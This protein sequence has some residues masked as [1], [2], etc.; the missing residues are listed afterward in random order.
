MKKGISFLL[1]LVSLVFILSA[2]S[3]APE[4]SDEPTEPPTDSAA[5]SEEK[6]EE[7]LKSI[8]EDYPKCQ[9]ID[10][11]LGSDE[12]EPIDFVT[13]VWEDETNS[14]SALLIANSLGVGKVAFGD[15]RILYR[16]E[17][18]LRLDKNVIY[19]SFDFIL[20]E[21]SDGSTT[22]EIHDYELA[23]TEEEN[24]DGVKGTV[25]TVVKDTTRQIGESKSE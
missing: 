11:V 13:A 23:V 16:P 15:K 25:Y 5:L 19:V 24:D 22:Y 6:T 12:N 7:Y 20:D 14:S 17:D 8:S 1:I 2:C 9:V 4:P 18:G 10:Y 3:A 21:N